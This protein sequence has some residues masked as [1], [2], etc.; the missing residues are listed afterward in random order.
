MGISK[1]FYKNAATY[2]RR[3]RII[4]N[5]NSRNHK[6]RLHFNNPPILNYYL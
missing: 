3:L 2:C 6:A 5:K 1:Y 4:A